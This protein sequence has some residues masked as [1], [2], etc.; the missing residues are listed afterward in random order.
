MLP[1]FDR[2][3]IRGQPPSIGGGVAAATAASG[4]FEPGCVVEVEGAGVG[5]AGGF[6]AG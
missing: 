6:A 5:G 4:G 1:P 2:L 3:R